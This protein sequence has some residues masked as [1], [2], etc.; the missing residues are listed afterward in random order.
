MVGLLQALPHTQLSRRLSREGRLIAGTPAE[1]VHTIT[2]INFIPRGE[3]TKRQ[4]LENYRR[5][6]K[7]VFKPAAYFARVLPGYLRLRSR[8][9]LA[10]LRRHGWD[11]ARVFLRE[12][13]HLGIKDPTMRAHFWKALLRVIVKNPAALEAFVFDCAVFHHLN[14]HAAYVDRTLSRRLAEP[15]PGD[16]LDVVATESCVDTFEPDRLRFVGG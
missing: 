16:I 11:F 4:Y 1:G 12:C 8:L 10:A 6:L 3:L 2:G 5:L 15:S 13:Y 9:R 7:D 14:L